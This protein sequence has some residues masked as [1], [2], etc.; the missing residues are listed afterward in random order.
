MPLPVAQAVVGGGDVEEVCRHAGTTVELAIDL[1]RGHRNPMPSDTAE[2]LVT[3]PDV[4]QGSLRR[5]SAGFAVQQQALLMIFE[6]GPACSSVFG[7]TP[8]ADRLAVMNLAADR[9]GL[10]EVVDALASPVA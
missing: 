5:R 3:R 10:F 7:I 4:A 2:V 8:A 1:E 6:R 9:H